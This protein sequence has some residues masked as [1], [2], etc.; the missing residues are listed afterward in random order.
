MLLDLHAHVV[1][2]RFPPAGTR[3]SSGRWPSMDHFEPGR[4]RVMI[5]GK[6]FRTVTEQNWSVARRLE[7]MAAEGV[8]AQA[9]SPMPELL[10][11]WLTP[12]DTRDLGRHVNE[13]IAGMVQAFPDRFY[14]LGMVP[15]QA[16]ELAATELAEVKRLGLHGVEVGSNVGGKSL[17][18][19][20]F[21]PFFQ[22][23]EA[24]D[25]P[26]FVH[27][28]H[29]TM[30]D[31]LPE[32]EQLAA[33]VA[34]PTD[35]G[36]TIA[37]LIAAGV[38]EKCPRLR[39]AFSHGGGSFPFILPR[40]EG[41]WSGGR[42]NGEPPPT[43]ES[44][45]ALRQRIPR[46]P[47]EYARRLYYDTLL[48]DRRAVRYLVEMVGG[49]QLVVG[50]DYPYIARERPVSRTLVSMGLSAEDFEAITWRNCRRFLGLDAA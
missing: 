34:F 44:P 26:V 19:V 1:P 47:T 14:G 43:A 46:S 35:T 50:T 17:G 28:L 32:I 36:L 30:T 11:Y 23:A 42:W 4:A 5:A 48:F 29:P 41:F 15:L 10:S 27:A 3:A 33:A 20:R 13:M 6:N 16:P 25:V 21:L 22:E 31:R 8:D 2:E 49:A 12:E 9:L 38:L 18:D 7:D 37:S 24:Q 40:L 45:G 39:L